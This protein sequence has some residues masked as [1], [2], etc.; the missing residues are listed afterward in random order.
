MTSFIF[1]SDYFIKSGNS[2]NIIGNIKLILIYLNFNII[3]LL[4]LK[5]FAKK[6]INYLKLLLQIDI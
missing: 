3:Y 1:I 4:F 5:S 2:R 6:Q